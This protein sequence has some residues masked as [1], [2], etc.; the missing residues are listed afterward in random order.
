MLVRD[1]M[2]LFQDFKAF[3][4]CE[5][6]NSLS[7]H[8]KHV[9]VKYNCATVGLKILVLLFTGP[10]NRDAMLS[11]RFTDDSAGSLAL[12]LFSMFCTQRT[13]MICPT[14]NM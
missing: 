5:L 11:R 7:G 2:F 3:L 14:P 4:C 9:T 12:I 6:R 13:K 8:N 10:T 1:T